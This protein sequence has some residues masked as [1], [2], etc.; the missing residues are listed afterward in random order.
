MIII[1]ILM[2]SAVL[3]GVLGLAVAYGRLLQKVDH[4]AEIVKQ[5]SE[6]EQRSQEN[7]QVIRD[8]F[9]RQDEIV[10]EHDRRFQRLEEQLAAMRRYHS[11]GTAQ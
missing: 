3:L 11:Y 5:R 7:M 10:K 2:N 8:G 4:I 9:A 6:V 1:G